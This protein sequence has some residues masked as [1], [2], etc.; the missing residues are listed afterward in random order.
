MPLLGAKPS[1]AFDGPSDAVLD[2][3]RRWIAHAVLVGSLSLSVVAAF[4]VQKAVLA[5]A[6]QRFENSA[7]EIASTI[8][9]RMESY[10][11]LLRGA[12]G[13]FSTR[14]ETD[15]SEF[16]AY[17]DRLA[18]RTNYSGIQG[19]GFSRRMTPKEA[20]LVVARMRDNFMPEFRIWPMGEREDYHAI[21]Y[22]E[23][24]NARNSA[25]IGFDMFTEPMRRRAMEQARDTGHRAASGIVPLVQE[26]EEPKENGFL[27]YIPIYK[28]GAIPET[29]VERRRQL[30]GFV[31]CAFRVPDFF[32][33]IFRDVR[34]PDIAVQ[35]YD[36]MAAA[37]NRIYE[38]ALPASETPTLFAITRQVDVAGHPWTIEV[39]APRHFATVGER[40]FAPAVLGLGAI[41]SV[42]LYLLTRGE[43]AARDLAERRAGELQERREW[44]RVTLSS[45]GD[46][47]IATDDEGRT[48]FMNPVAEKLTGWTQS[49]AADRPLAEIFR[50][51]R[52]GTS[53]ELPTPAAQVLREGR[54]VSLSRQACLIDREGE[55]RPID[56][57]AAP[58]RDRTGKVIG[59]VLVFHDVAERRRIETELQKE[60]SERRIAQ[61]ALRESEERFRLLV[62]NAQDIAI[63]MTDRE[64]LISSW[65]TGAQRILGLSESEVIG[66]PTSILFTPEDRSLG[67]PAQEIQTATHT[68]HASDER[69]HLRKDGSR[70]WATG[71]LIALRDARGELRGFAKIMRDITARKHAEEE[72]Q[73]LNRELEQRV[74][75]RT[76]ALE[77][78]N[79]QME[80]F[81]YTVAHDLRAPLRAMRG[82]SQVLL[83]DFGERLDDTGTDYLQRIVSS[84]QRMDSLIQDLLAYSRLSRV[85]LVAEPVDLRMLAATVLHYFSEEIREKQAKVTV[86]RDLPCVLGHETTLSQVLGNLLTNALKFVRPGVVP[87]IQIYTTQRGD[88]VRLWVEDNGIGIA[89]E[90]RER[91][92]G[93]FERL[94]ENSAYPGT[95]IGLAIVRK[96]AERMG[97]TAGVE[98]VAGKGS[99]FWIE[100]RKYETEKNLR[101]T[102]E[103]GNTAAASR[104]VADHQT[105]ATEQG[106]GQS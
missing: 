103:R 75:Q 101:Q 94:H 10:V 11:A 69:W 79:E 85:E 72:I 37:T 82:F 35:A 58:I 32:Q 34:N 40:A 71:Y 6:R 3:R 53:I 24:V 61:E 86:A 28:E 38:R 99:R 14:P 91:I 105:Q 9:G 4:Y 96:G 66:K 20:D 89:D 1:D 43:I 64:G 60:L 95:G 31:Y 18:L 47:V 16:R 45:I 33:E 39:Q 59:V 65:N 104:P 49:E 98:S 100:V 21:L 13:L 78:S 52:E 84:A 46:G 92:F 48:K 67:I 50:I 54:V 102:S 73:Q 26:I 25:A 70:F 62:E 68:G 106:V 80:A 27:V 42:I 97:G 2:R 74:Q 57:S 5:K 76:A 22:L 55:P 77:E 81:T 8:E 12:A 83:E 93:I 29:V 36:G 63:F 44:L 23:P 15:K 87:E 17:V 56:E 90:H 51:V 41:L 88:R 7:I 19:L 30:A